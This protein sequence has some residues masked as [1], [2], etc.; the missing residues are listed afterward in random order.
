MAHPKFDRLV[1]AADDRGFSRPRA[2]LMQHAAECTKCTGEIRWIRQTID[3]MRTDNSEAA[4]PHVLA[5]AW[6]ILS[7]ARS[8]QPRTRRMPTLDYFVGHLRFDSG[9]AAA[10]SS[11]RSAAGQA[12]R[13]RIFQAACFGIDVQVS[14]GRSE[15]LVRGQVLGAAE[16]QPGT[17][18]LSGA[19]ARAEAIMNELLEFQL[20]A[21]PA[22]I[23]TMDVTIGS[24]LVRIQSL[25]LG[26]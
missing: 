1:D 18:R 8:S 5:R 21:L 14:H 9:T 24:S 19:T 20:P 17:V 25:E 13:R 6:R 22:G 10:N 26:P 23:Y 7:N 11:V 4:S 12:T 2:S 16:A 3:L 15:W